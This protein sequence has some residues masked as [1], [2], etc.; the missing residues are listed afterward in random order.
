M[1]GS[2]AQENEK[3]AKGKHAKAKELSKLDPVDGG[4]RPPEEIAPESVAHETG[5]NRSSQVT[6]EEVRRR[7]RNYRWCLTFDLAEK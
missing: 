1:N 6:S 7:F 3:K 4:L 2:I 5:A